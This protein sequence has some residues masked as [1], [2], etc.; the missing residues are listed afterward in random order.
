MSE[1]K[2]S[3]VSTSGKDEFIENMKRLN[4]ALGGPAGDIKEV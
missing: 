3:G 2:G 4:R 1:E